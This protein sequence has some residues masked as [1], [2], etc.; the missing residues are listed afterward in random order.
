LADDED[1]A[2]ETLEDSPCL[3]RWEEAKRKIKEEEDEMLKE[4]EALLESFAT[5]R[6][7]E[8]TQVATAQA[9]HAEASPCGPGHVP[10]CPQFSVKRFAKVAQIWKS[11]AERGKA[12]GGKVSY[13]VKG[14]GAAAVIVVIFSNNEE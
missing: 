11:A 7:E 13:P 4:Q 6:K 12:F 14:E 9:I 5:A 8:R 3:E 2:T 1:A 10:A